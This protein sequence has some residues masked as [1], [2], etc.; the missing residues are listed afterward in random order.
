M[1]ET[2][3]ELDCRDRIDAVHHMCDTASQD[4]AVV[5]FAMLWN[6]DLDKMDDYL[7]RS[8]TPQ[9]I[10]EAAVLANATRWFSDWESAKTPMKKTQLDGLRDE[11]QKDARE[12]IKGYGLKLKSLS[13]TSFQLLPKPLDSDDKK[14]AK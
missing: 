13:V 6:I 11:V 2:I 12:A 1:G 9:Q 10:L 14:K 7:G 8:K 5:S 3:A 4:K